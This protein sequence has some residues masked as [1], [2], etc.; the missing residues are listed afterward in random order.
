MP[1]AAPLI[2]T[3]TLDAHSQ[4]A[5]D[6]LRQ[7]H[8]PAE[9]LLVGAHV[10]LFHALPGD[11]TAVVVAELGREAERTAIM[12]VRVGGVRLLGRGVAFALEST[13]LTRLRGRLR[14]RW[15]EWLTP[16]DRQPWRPHV[17]IQNKVDPA[18]AKALHAALLADFIPY[19]VT[20]IGLDLWLYR[21]GPWEPA[22][23][24]RF[25]GR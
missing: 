14:G 3:L 22:G 16:Q 9:R 23:G 18:S 2:L 5:F 6:A 24:F 10:T 11:L 7:A 25:T 21:H 20:G 19:D 8:F 1:D 15:A 12:P 17:T 4:A 13:P